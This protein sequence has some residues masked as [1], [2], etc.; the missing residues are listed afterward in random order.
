[1]DNTEMLS[2]ILSEIRTINA[3]LSNLEEG[4]KALEEGQKALEEGQKA[5]EEGQAAIRRDISRLDQ[6]IDT[7]SSNVGDVML[8]LTENVDKEIIKLKIVK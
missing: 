4:Q 5:L 1:M 6:K 8:K 7:L 2:V 3:R